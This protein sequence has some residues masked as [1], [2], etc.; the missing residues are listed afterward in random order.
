MPTFSRSASSPSCA[1][2]S[3]SS[4]T[5]RSPSLHQRLDRVLRQL[6]RRHRPGWAGVVLDVADHRSRGQFLV[7]LGFAELASH[8]PVAGSDLPVVEAP[9]A[10]DAGLVHRLVLLLGPGRDGHARSRSSSP[11]WSTGSWVLVGT[12]LTSPSSTRQPRRVQRH[13]HVHRHQRRSSSR[14][15]STRSAS[16]CSRSSTTSASATEILGMLVF[17]LILLFFANV[18]SRSVLTR[19][20]GPEPAQNGNIPATFAL[21][22]FMSL[23]ILYG[24]DTAGTFGEETH[25]REPPGAARRPVVD[26]DLGPRRR[27]LPARRSSSPR[28]TS[29][30]R[31]PTAWPAASRS[32]RRSRTTFSPDLI[33]GITVGRRDLPVRHPRLGLRLHAGDPGRRDPDDVLDGSRRAP[34]VRRRLGPRQR[35]L[36]H[37]G[38]RRHR[39]RRP[40]RDPDPASSGRSRHLPLDRRH[41]PDL[42][43]YFLCNAGVLAA[44]SAA[45]RTRRPG[46]ASAAGAC[47]QHPRADLR[48][49]HDHQHRPVGGRRS[50][51]G[52]FGAPTDALFWNPLINTFINRSATRSTG[53][54]PGRC[55]RR[56]SACS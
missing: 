4:R 14:R 55:S 19:L 52:D 37:A 32:R 25:R 7:A 43:R 16:G 50:L 20:R 22:F 47:R 23:F 13:V 10:P 31:W 36:P 12:R 42:R 1:G 11:S 24:F 27:D 3:G 26:P 56:S 9:V 44:R 33:G 38:Q 35:A 17:A 48:R 5:S 46:S 54:R 6:R 29:R 49:P 15:S 51:F 40:R 53:C 41:R 45:G 18:Q 34:P 21:G 2:R 30:R 28:P 39:G 8:Y